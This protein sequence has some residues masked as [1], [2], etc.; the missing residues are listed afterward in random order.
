MKN[1]IHGGDKYAFSRQASAQ[2]TLIDF[3]ANTNPLGMPKKVKEAAINAIENSE[4]YPDPFCRKLTETIAKAES[5]K[6]GI[7][8]TE[9]NIICGNGAADLIFRSIYA[10][11]LKKILVAAPT[12]SEYENAAKEKN[13]EIEYYYL[14]EENEFNFTEEILDH[15][16]EDIDGIFLCNPNN[17]VGNL[18]DKKLLHKILNKAKNINAFLL[19]DECFL[20][21][22]GKEKENSMISK[23][24]DFDN[25]IIFKAFTK[26]YAMAGLRL[27]YILTGNLDVS[28]KIFNI[29][30]PW[31]VSTPAQAAGIEAVSE[32]AFLEKS[33]K[34]IKK[35]REILVDALEK[36]GFKVYNGMANFIF[37]KG[38]KDLVKTM[39]KKG[40]LLRDCSNYK[41]LSEGYMR[42][43]V[44][45]EE[46]NREFIE[47]L[48]EV[49]CG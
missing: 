41:G 3:S 46:E 19:L 6:S 17:P 30:Q 36:E 44:R 49:L 4:Y 39:E 20:E 32:N 40:I 15:I 23:L 38:S 16:T 21:L 12:F 2:C 33:V 24:K 8:I 25:L 9:D 18:I 47:K 43:A 10:L 1:Y 11:N 42:I 45:R 48:K 22:T 26:T 34:Y 13:I 28:D 29:G 35:Q 14:K 5:K 31:S 37:F 27:G 7:K